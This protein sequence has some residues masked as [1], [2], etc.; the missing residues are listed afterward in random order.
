[1]NTDARARQTLSIR[2]IGYCGLVAALVFIWPV[3]GTIALRHL[4]LGILLVLLLADG[5][6]RAR[7]GGVLR[8]LATPVS[9]LLLLTGWI[10]V[11]NLN[12]VFQNRHLRIIGGSVASRHGLACSRIGKNRR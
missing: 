12:L 7:I 3:V 6:V 5:A 4:L 1:M 11:H 9:L 2:D 8:D 10:V